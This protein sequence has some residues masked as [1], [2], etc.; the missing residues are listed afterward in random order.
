MFW[1]IFQTTVSVLAL[2]VALFLARPPEEATSN[3]S[4]WLRYMGI[5]NASVWLP[6]PIVVYLCLIAVAVL[7][8]I[9]PYLRTRK[10]IAFEI[11][12]DT[13]NPGYQ[14]CSHRTIETFSSQTAGI[15]YRVKIRNKTQR[16][17]REVKATTETLGP[18]GAT[19]SRLIFDQTGQDSFTLDPGTSAFVKL[20]FT[21]L[22]LI[23]PGML[24]GSSTAAYGPSESL[25]APRIQWQ[26]KGCSDL[27]L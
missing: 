5:Q 17:L 21:S 8:W 24:M 9:I 3:V 16:T 25:S 6:R 18:M 26:L 13:K 15:E 12:F 20:F 11:V 19:P 27:I 4:K 7:V 23:Q 2:V 14:F 22:P 1:K 10:A